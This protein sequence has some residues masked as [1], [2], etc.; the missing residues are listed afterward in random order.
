MIERIAAGLGLTEAARRDA[1]GGIPAAGDSSPTESENLAVA[2]AEKAALAELDLLR[3]HA[4]EAETA[5]RQSEETLAKTKAAWRAA[6]VSKPPQADDLEFGRRRMQAAAANY[7]RFMQEHDLRRDA[8]DRSAFL[9][10]ALAFAAI[11][12]ESAVNS[13]FF[14]QASAHGLLGGFFYAIM[15]SFVNVVFAFVGGALGLRYIHHRDAGKKLA[16]LLGFFGCLTV[17][18]LIV[19]VCALYRG[20]LDALADQVAVDELSSAA[21]A[22]ARANIAGWRIGAAFDSLDSSL[23]VVVGALCAG[24]G[25]WEGYRIDDAYP[26]FG[27]MRRQKDEAEEEFRDAKQAAESQ[28]AAHRDKIAAAL[29]A[30]AEKIE[31]ADAE[32]RVALEGLR[33]A[34]HRADNLPAQTARLA[35]ALLARYRGENR[36]TRAEPPPLYFDRYPQGGDFEALFGEWERIKAKCAALEARVTPLS[37]SCRAEVR[38]IRRE[39]DDREPPR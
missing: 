13:Y 21:W 6:A 20:A 2:E 26:G 28:I 23:L 19:A 39:I 36:K 25:A 37:E 38:A 18:A 24:F 30:A 32:M 8:E 35:Q 5:A 11:V 22:A 9:A 34:L 3:P 16:G 12:A 17:C 27:K 29:A 15:F 14:A 1:A 4:D 7:N 10:A 33:A 31:S